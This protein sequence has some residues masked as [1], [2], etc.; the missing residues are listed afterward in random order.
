MAQ[1][2]SGR[3]LVGEWFW[4]FLALVMV[5]AV[6][7]VAWIAYQL[8]P[9]PLV[10]AAAF[11]A[12]AKARAARNVH[13]VIAPAAQPAKEPAAVTSEAPQ[14]P[15]PEAPA[16]AAQPQPAP[17]P[18]AAAPQPAPEPKEPP[19]KVDKLRLSDSIETPIAA[20]A[21]KK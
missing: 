15:K 21:K 7:W 3:K 13:G 16:A 5:A 9:P 4:R 14:G 8:N 19:V 2:P 1:Q 18:V 10:T 6:G 12:A 11:E 20:K 17:P